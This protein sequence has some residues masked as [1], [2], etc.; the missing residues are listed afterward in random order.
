[1]VVEGKQGRVEEGVRGHRLLDDRR[2]V[3]AHTTG[4]DCFR[5][6]SVDQHVGDGRRLQLALRRN[7][8]HTEGNFG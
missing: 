5:E 4:V 1:M 7:V 6:A 2:V 8:I 3:A